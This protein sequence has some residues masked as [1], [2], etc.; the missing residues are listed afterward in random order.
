M[1]SQNYLVIKINLLNIYW[2]YWYVMYVSSGWSGFHPKEN[3]PWFALS[4]ASNNINAVLLVWHW[5]SWFACVLSFGYWCAGRLPLL[6]YLSR[7]LSRDDLF[8]VEL[9]IVAG[10]EMFYSK[11]SPIWTDMIAFTTFNKWMYCL[12]LGC[13]LSFLTTKKM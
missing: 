10:D 4:K 8:R 13:K 5:Y 1:H 3:L 7:S 12:L 9:D 2:K 11:V 6:L